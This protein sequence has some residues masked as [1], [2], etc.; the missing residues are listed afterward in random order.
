M[1]SR[2]KFYPLVNFNLVK[3]MYKIL[4]CDCNRLKLY[5]QG[6]EHESSLY[7]DGCLCQPDHEVFECKCE[8]CRYN[9]HSFARNYFT[10]VTLVV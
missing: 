2:A 7:F 8:D 9:V 3:K 4:M 6:T 1:R 10:S 5:E